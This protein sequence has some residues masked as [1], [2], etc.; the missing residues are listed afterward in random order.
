MKYL[1][2]LLLLS[3]SNFAHSQIENNNTDFLK[4]YS[5]LIYG[6]KN[7]KIQNGT[8]FFIRYKGTL[9][10]VTA[11]HVVTGCRGNG[12]KIKFQP[13]TMNI[14]NKNKLSTYPIYVK[15]MYEKSICYPQYVELD[16]EVYKIDSH[17][18]LGL[19][20]VDSFIGNP[21]FQYNE[22]ATQGFPFYNMIEGNEYDIMKEPILI[23]IEAPNFW[24][25]RQYS[26]TTNT[27]EDTLNYQ[28]NF[29]EH[30]DQ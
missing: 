1:F 14:L 28:L 26:D 5:Y 15:D 7:Q 21:F 20:T 16:I 17:W 25:T 13:D 11:R 29:W 10:F 3:K 8:G 30:C 19:N 23:T 2:I 18:D 4:K 6:E 24:M 22:F 9:Y 12:Q 27:K